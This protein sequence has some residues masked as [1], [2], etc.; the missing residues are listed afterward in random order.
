MNC[1]LLQAVAR[2]S[3]SVKQTYRGGYPQGYV[4]LLC[5]LISMCVRACCERC[6]DLYMGHCAV[7]GPLV[8]FA[9]AS[10]SKS[11]WAVWVSLSLAWRISPG[12]HHLIRLK[13]WLLLKT[14][15][16]PPRQPNPP[17]K[18][19]RH[20]ERNLKLRRNIFLLSSFISRHCHFFNIWHFIIAILVA[21]SP[22]FGTK[23]NSSKRMF[24]SASTR[25][26]RV[27]LCTLKWNKQ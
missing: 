16:T 15:K 1:E 27:W 23:R 7:A 22:I 25:L 4:L 13:R 14:S 2:H 24:L 12:P 20:I 8:Y 18:Q 21:L 11:P 3:T 10:L 17:E 26:G 5:G 6:E 9:P 19:E